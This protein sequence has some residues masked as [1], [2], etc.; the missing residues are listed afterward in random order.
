MNI[1][2]TKL[3][4]ND[5]EELDCVKRFLPFFNKENSTS[6]SIVEKNPIQ[7]EVDIFVSDN[8]NN[9][10]KLQVTKANYLDS[11]IFN[12]NKNDRIKRKTTKIECLVIDKH[13][14]E[15]CLQSVRSK[16]DKYKNKKIDDI[17]LLLDD[18]HTLEKVSFKKRFLEKGYDNLN[19]H[20]KEV[21][22][23]GEKDNIAYKVF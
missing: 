15:P 16:I 18:V 19:K 3:T 10:L 1:R 21:W 5:V 11:N 2:K 17:I 14:I 7:N 9:L 4:A 13:N 12:K 20:F 23:V 8:N 6:F 22:Y